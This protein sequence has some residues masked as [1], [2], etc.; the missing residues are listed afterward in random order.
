M[1]ADSNA[2]SDYDAGYETDLTEVCAD[3]DADEEGN[4]DEDLDI[5]DLDELFA[6]N[7]HPPKY[8]IQ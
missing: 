8:Y 5:S 6:D 2:D 3:A 1:D 7:K 4:G